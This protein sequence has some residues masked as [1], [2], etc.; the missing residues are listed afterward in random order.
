MMTE[1]AEEALSALAYAGAGILLLMLGYLVL[2][3]L[4]PGDLR[5][6]VYDERN[7]NAALV[8]SSG[9]LAISFIV[10]TAII[11]SDNDF[12]EGIAGTFGYGGLGV[13]LLGFC[14]VIVDKL[15]PG[16]LGVICTDREPHPAVYVTVAS[17]LA[18]GIILAAAVS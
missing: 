16:E 4:T 2:D 10:G 17:Q 11:T 14:F 18:L 15:T 8:V 5:R 13:V 9:L 1:L 3:L 12:S 7:R 6:L